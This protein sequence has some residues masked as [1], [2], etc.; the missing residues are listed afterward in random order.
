MIET[1]RSRAILDAS[2]LVPYWSRVALRKLALQ[3]PAPYQPVWSTAI[4]AETWRILGVR[5]GRAGQPATTVSRSAHELWRLLDP[6]FLIADASQPPAGAPPSPLRDPNDAHLWYAALHSGAHYVVSHNT[7]DFPPLVSVVERVG[8]REITVARH[9]YAGIEFLTAIEFI[10]D[11]LGANAALLCG[12]SLP[13]G[14]PV[15][16]QR[17]R[18]PH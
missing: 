14:A 4:V 11:V 10:G 1:A 16:S 12:H 6:L 18:S 2:V 3:Q 7:R 15:R 17:S 9:V 13:P 8:E 5:A